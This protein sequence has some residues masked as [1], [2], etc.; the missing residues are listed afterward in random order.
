MSNYVSGLRKSYDETWTKL[1]NLMSDADVGEKSTATLF[2][3]LGQE[4]KFPLTT[5][6]KGVFYFP[7]DRLKV[8]NDSW[9]RFDANQS[10]P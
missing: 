8:K 10:F 9:V 2:K 4:G 1:T 5:P 7:V 6:P 3:I